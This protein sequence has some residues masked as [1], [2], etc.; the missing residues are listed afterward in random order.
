M[1]TE[2]EAKNLRQS[3][4]SAGNITS[5]PTYLEL[6]YGSVSAQVPAKTVSIFNSGLVDLLICLSGDDATFLTIPPGSCFDWHR[7]LYAVTMKTT[8]GTTSYSLAA[9]Y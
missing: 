8:S 7:Q 6:F 3:F 9:G 1:A 5:S 2:N 4:F